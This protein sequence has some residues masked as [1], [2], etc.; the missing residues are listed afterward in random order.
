MVRL[1]PQGYD[2]YRGERL[3]M[4]DVMLKGRYGVG[5]MVVGWLIIVMVIA[6]GIV[7]VGQAPQW[8]R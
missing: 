4:G 3:R 5:W 7:V 1:P 6:G 8:W 2:G